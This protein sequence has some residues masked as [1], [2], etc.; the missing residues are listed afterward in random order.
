[1]LDAVREQSDEDGVA[2]QA[3]V[4][5]RR[6]M[7]QLVAGITRDRYVAPA[8]GSPGCLGWLRKD[9]DMTDKPVRITASQI[10]IILQRAAEID[11]K[12]D[13]MSV[14]ELR[15]IAAEAGID[16]GATN[17]AIQEIMAGEEPDPH[18][19]S[20]ESPGVPAR[21]STSPSTPR[22]LAGGAIGTAMGFL[23][24]FAGG[25]AASTAWP[26]LGW[27]GF[28]GTVL[29]L[30]ARA[31]ECM[32][33]GAQLDFQLQNLALWFGVSVGALATD[34]LWADD[35]LTVAILVWFLTSVLG[36]LLVRFGPKDEDGDDPTRQIE[37]GGG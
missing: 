16:P 4:D 9:D 11:A 34:L 6:E 17:R 29:Y 22:I 15:R 36:G 13:S 21:K 7:E 14:E 27:L 1:M 2:V 33:R 5:L 19:V 20:T 30:V 10:S 28:G 25:G 12:G 8:L 35:I 32:K 3:M 18:L 37:P 24:A 31:V 23:A 26:M